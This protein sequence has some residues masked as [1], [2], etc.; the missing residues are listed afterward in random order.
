MEKTSLHGLHDGGKLPVMNS[1]IPRVLSHITAT[2]QKKTLYNHRIR[3][4]DVT[5]ADK[6]AKYKYDS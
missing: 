4:S 5:F 3:S 2:E 1:S 6:V